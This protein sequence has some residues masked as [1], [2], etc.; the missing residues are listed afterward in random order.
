MKKLAEYQKKRHFERTPEPKPSVRPAKS[1]K[2]VFV[3]QKHAATRLH[4]DLRLEVDGVLKSWAVPKGPSLNPADKRLAVHVEDHPFDYR[5]FEGTIPKSQ[6]G[7]GEVIV[8]DE[9][10]YELEGNLD[11]HAQ[12]ARG[13]LKF[14]LHGKKVR[15]SFVLVEIKSSKNKNEWLLIK[16]K[17]EFVDP[18]WDAEKHPRSVLTS[19]TLEDVKLGRAASAPLDSNAIASIDGAR[20]SPMPRSV[21]LTLAS[22][23]EKPFS[24]KD[25][26]FEVKWDG[27][28]GLAFV[29]NGE[30][31][32]QSRAARD[33]S[34]EFPEVRELANQLTAT[35]AIVDGEIVALDNTGRSVFQKLQNRSG[36]RNPSRALLDSIPATYY[37][38]DLLY[39]DGYDLRKTP[40]E[41]RKDLL[42]KILRLNARIRYSEHEIEKGKELYEAARQQGLEGII[43]KKR[44]S[45]YVGQRTSL[46]LKFKIVAELDAVVCGWTAP[47]R[48]R[49]FFGALVLGLYDG[50]ELQFI[51]SVGTGF[52]HAKQRNIFDQL[53][54]LKQ[55]DSPFTESPRLKE[56][57]VWVAPQRVARVK[58]GNWTDGLRLRAPVFIGMRDDISAE[59]C[60]VQSSGAPTSA[61]APPAEAAA[62]NPPRSAKTTVASS[63]S[64]SRPAQEPLPAAAPAPP[65]PKA[66]KS[67]AR[68]GERVITENIEHEIRAGASENLNVQIDGQFLRLTHLN[69]IY[70]PGSAIRKR[71]LLAY[72][73]RTGHLML[74]FLKDR[75]MVLRRYPNGIREKA[76]FQKEAPDS[77][78]DWL[79]RATV[80]SE[81]RGREMPYIMA[82]N[83]AAIIYLTNLGCIDHNPWS[84]R[85]ASQDFPDYVFFD[86]DPTPGTPFS[87][88]LQIAL[89]IHGIL[90]SIRLK[91]YLKTS[92]ASGFHIFVPLKPEY[93]YEQTR[94]FAELVGR[95]ASDE[96]PGLIT[97][98]RIVSKRPRGKVLMDALQNARGKPLATVY[99]ARAYPGAP[100]STPVTPAELKKEF[101]ADQWTIKT[102]E[103]RLK[104][105]GNLWE[106]FWKNR[107]S[108][109]QALEFLDQRLSSRRRISAPRAGY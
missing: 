64:K 31:T 49:E 109:S 32:V 6:Y 2:T 18:S 53:Q 88:V 44:D 75:P 102:L 87:T 38:F 91:C 72:Y 78:P 93:I 46:W 15:G 33:I 61:T 56:A 76:F 16:H 63:P 36:V 99:S 104:K 41:Q 98:E 23:S 9:G 20:K 37:A 71:D 90:D 22:L 5:K 65:P 35:E 12:I 50:P 28:R 80:Y 108:L 67:P 77:I 84:S 86:L 55:P 26:L 30:V 68:P 17:D 100:V 89:T 70:F 105:V 45:A 106:G 21:S 60:T 25:W 10:A 62:S 47:R 58:Y 94:G 57:I 69:K 13:D 1:G 66:P 101:A 34:P 24:N 7:G 14:N 11:F 103:A 59:T 39:C 107:Q 48:S 74:P 95:M 43:G 73:F 92:G 79:E 52:D 3:I 29:S 8:W 51:G 42:K 54:K 27:V 81:E 85:A 40:L 96:L 97:F 83:L 82:N 4:Y 19:R